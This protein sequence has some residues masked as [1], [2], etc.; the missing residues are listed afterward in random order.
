MVGLA[1]ASGGDTNGAMWIP[2][3]G[4]SMWPCLRPGDEAEISSTEHRGIDEGDVVLARVV[5]RL[6]I[7]RV[8]AVRVDDVLLRGDNVAQGDPPIHRDHVLGVVMRVRR[9][10][11]VLETEEWSRRPGPL[12]LLSMRICQRARLLRARS[13]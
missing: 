2:V 1:P 3:K 6:V 9:E 12:R 5:D 4:N 11:E 10:G 13:P 7:H 8:L